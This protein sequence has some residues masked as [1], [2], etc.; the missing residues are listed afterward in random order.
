MLPMSE[1]INVH[2][3]TIHHVNGGTVTVFVDSKVLASELHIYKEI[4]TPH[5][6]PIIVI[7]GFAKDTQIELG[8]NFVKWFDRLVIIR[9][10]DISSMVIDNK[11]QLIIEME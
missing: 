11:P 1:V 7:K 4:G 5:S 6:T 8:M 2:E 3:I 9:T 10:N